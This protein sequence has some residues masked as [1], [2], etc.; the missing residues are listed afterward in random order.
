MR[1]GQDPIILMGRRNWR[2][3]ITL[4]E[5]GFLTRPTFNEIHFLLSIT[6]PRQLWMYRPSRGKKGFRRDYDTVGSIKMAD[7]RELPPLKPFFLHQFSPLSSPAI[8]PLLSIH[9]IAD[10]RCVVPCALPSPSTSISWWWPIIKRANEPPK[11]LFLARCVCVCV[12]QFKVKLPIIYG[13]R[14]HNLTVCSQPVYCVSRRI[15]YTEDN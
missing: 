14:A 4:C 6:K 10:D 12:S 1:A 2:N 8:S 11:L 13:A 9:I 5:N 7:C 3:Y 15:S